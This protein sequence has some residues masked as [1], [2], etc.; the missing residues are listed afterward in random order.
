MLAM[1][2]CINS[3]LDGLGFTTIVGSSENPLCQLIVGGNPTTTTTYQVDRWNHVSCFD[4][5]GHY[6]S[7]PVGA[8]PVCCYLGVHGRGEC[9]FSVV[10]LSSQAWL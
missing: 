4:R 7:S 8:V 10:P 1:I 3:I 9:M 5:V 2:V 6:S